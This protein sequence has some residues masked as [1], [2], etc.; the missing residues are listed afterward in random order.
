MYSYLTPYENGYKNPE[1]DYPLPK[2]V[3]SLLE[4]ITP[5][6][7]TIKPRVYTSCW[8]SGFCCELSTID[9]NMYIRSTTVQKFC[10]IEKFKLLEK[11]PHVYSASGATVVISF[12]N[13]WMVKDWST[14]IPS[15]IVFTEDCTFDDTWIMTPFHR[16]PIGFYQKPLKEDLEIIRN[17][18]RIVDK[19]ID[20][21]HN[22]W[23]IANY[24]SKRVLTKV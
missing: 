13:K 24:W 15:E 8:L 14:V 23:Y 20:F 21:T 22:Q 5:K 3:A 7:T 9:F 4:K 19:G 2:E 17:I 18:A 1:T 6:E 12:D 10:I 11:Y 16:S